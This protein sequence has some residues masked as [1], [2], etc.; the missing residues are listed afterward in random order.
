MPEPST[1]IAALADLI[2]DRARIIGDAAT[3]V[4]DVEHDSRRVRPGALYACF[5]GEKSDGHDHAR[6]AMAAGAA[7]LLVSR[8]LDVD[9]PQL[10]VDDTRAVVGSIAGA[11]H[12]NPSRD[13]TVIGVT[14]TNGKTTVTHL[15]GDVLT[16]TAGRTEIL[17]TLSGARTTPEA[18]E[19][20]RRL[21]EWSDAG[22]T[23]VAMEVSSHSLAAGR[24]SGIRFALSIFT[25]LSPD[26]LDFHSSMES[27]FAAK[28]RLFEPVLS[29][30]AV[31][32]TDDSHGR[33]LL[34]AAAIP[35][36]GFGLADA[37]IVE[38]TASGSS[39]L[40][41]GERVALDLV[42]RFNI[43]N[44]LAA[45]TAARQ[46]GIEPSAIARALSST[47][48]VPGRFEPVRAGQPFAVFVDY[49]H[50]PDALEHAMVTARRLIAPAGR[51]YVV[52]GCGG[53]RDPSKRPLMG[54]V[55][56]EH[57]DLAVLT[58]D[59]PRTEDPAA[60]MSDVLAG[61]PPGSLRV[62]P[63]RAAAIRSVLTEAADGDIVV[64]A[65]KGHET[66]QTIGDRVVEFD[67]RVVALGILAELGFGSVRQEA[68]Q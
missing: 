14:G 3:I 55:A 20:Q 49:S 57:A 7:A 39:F 54:T 42:G 59:N 46:L 10:I 51:V 63:D 61:T 8:Q 67:D 38:E 36:V 43:S 24:V 41:A 5:V 48:A 6:E 58:A 68:D 25:N 12:G 15:L 32:N 9:L 29:D 19:L 27:Y 13:L 11:V 22:V 50:T 35:T 60:I 30:Q 33:L 4:S 34:D 31:V 66:T 52:F 62:E 2:G 45:A 37:E 16:S 26:H 18:P 28:A 21:A 17:G 47:T 23:H 44:A 40:W 56:A 53:D 64:I 65:G 1:S